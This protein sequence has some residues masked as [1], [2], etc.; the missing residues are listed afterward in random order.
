MIVTTP[1][2]PRR[3]PADVQLRCDLVVIPPRPRSQRALPLPE[4]RRLLRP[5]VHP[6]LFFTRRAP[7]GLP[8]NYQRP[9]GPVHDDEDTLAIAKA[10]AVR[11]RIEA[12]YGG[13]SRTSSVTR[14]T[15]LTRSMSELVER[16]FAR[17]WTPLDATR[18]DTDG[19]PIEQMGALRQPGD[20]DGCARSATNCYVVL[21]ADAEELVHVRDRRDRDMFCLND[22]GGEVDPAAVVAL[23]EEFSR[24]RAAGNALAETGR[25]APPTD[26]SP[27]RPRNTAAP[28]AVSRQG[29]HN[30]R[31]TVSSTTSTGQRWRR[32]PPPWPQRPR[33]P[34]RRRRCSPGARRR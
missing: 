5:P 14:R 18:S 6:S 20:R 12:R 24:C 16:E 29:E 13:P 30:G 31:S 21:G 32:P 17:D 15:A 25:Q 2:R 7:E 10:K 23:L 9:L 33:C 19:L 27:T 8:S 26:G 4:R 22:D 3:V 28:V 11:S 34:P 1:N